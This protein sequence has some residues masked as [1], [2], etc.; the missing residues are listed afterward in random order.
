MLAGLASLVAALRA[1]EDSTEVAGA[2][3]EWTVGAVTFKAAA[4]PMQRSSSS[5]SGGDRGCVLRCRGG[6][7]AVV[8]ITPAR[9]LGGQQDA[10][11]EGDSRFLRLVPAMFT[12][13]AAAERTREVG[14]AVGFTDIPRTRS[15]LTKAL[16]T[17]LGGMV[18]AWL[19]LA[20]PRTLPCLWRP[21]LSVRRERERPAQRPS[22]DSRGS[23][24]PRR[25]SR[26]C[27]RLRGQREPGGVVPVS[28]CPSR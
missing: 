17:A 26:L 8:G 1:V 28:P 22:P 7:R 11:A 4:L 25:E 12:L 3:G 10:P 5:S 20:L 27:E 23:V 14:R 21:P 24:A 18:S 9:F 6:R 2:A 15:H 16:C 19:C 13:V